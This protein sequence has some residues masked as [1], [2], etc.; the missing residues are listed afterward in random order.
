MRGEENCRIRLSNLQNAWA[1]RQA[2]RF[3]KRPTK[4]L[5]FWGQLSEWLRRSWWVRR[6]SAPLLYYYAIVLLLLLYGCRASLRLLC[7]IMKK[8]YHQPSAVD[9]TSTN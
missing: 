2:K 5:V 7:F 3:E 8:V 4:R 6:Q 1:K 9:A